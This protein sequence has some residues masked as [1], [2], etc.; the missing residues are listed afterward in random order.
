MLAAVDSRRGRSSQATSGFHRYRL[1]DFVDDDVG[2]S[3]A[4]YA[5]PDRDWPTN[6][7]HEPAAA[8]AAL[9]ASRWSMTLCRAKLRPT[10]P[11]RHGEPRH[12]EMSALD[13][14]SPPL[15]KAEQIPVVFFLLD[16][17]RLNEIK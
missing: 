8:S 14:I 9:A 2:P 6:E 5:E 11:G 13:E 15:E 7:V 1:E 12:S 10:P 16:I 4:V 3:A 17:E